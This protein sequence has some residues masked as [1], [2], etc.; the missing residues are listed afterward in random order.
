MYDSKPVRWE[1]HL[2]A[3][4]NFLGFQATSG[5]GK[6]NDRG[7]VRLVP[8]KTR[9]AAI[10]PL[11]LA[12]K[13]TYTWGRQL[14]DKSTKHDRSQDERAAYLALLDRCVQR[15]SN[16]E[17][18]TILGFLRNWSEEAQPLPVEMTANDLCTFVVEGI[19]PLDDPDVQRF[20]ARE[21]G[22]PDASGTPGQCLVCGAQTLVVDRLPVQLKGL[23]G[24]QASGVALVSANSSAFE[25]YGRTAA[26]TSPICLD[27]GER[28]GKAA[29]ALIQG[30]T[31]HLS[32]GPVVYL[33]WTPQ[34]EWDVVGF[35]KE[36]D[37]E[38]VRLLLQSAWT[39]RLRSPSD[40]EAFYITALS[41]AMSR[42][43][44]RS[45]LQTTV[46]EVRSSLRRWFALQSLIGPDGVDG[47][48]LSVFRL[49]VSLY[50]EAK[51]ILKRVPEALIQN[52]LHGGPLPT[53]LIHQAVL[54]NQAERKVTYPRAALIKAVLCSQSLED[55]TTMAALNPD[56]P[57]AAYHCGRL[58]AR[59]ESIQQAAVPGIKATLVDRYYAG[60][61]AAPA[62]VFGTLLS[63]AQDHL[64]KL[65]KNERGTY[66]ALSMSLEQILAAVSAFPNTLTVQDQALFSL[67][68]YHQRA[69]D[70]AARQARSAAKRAAQLPLESAS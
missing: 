52:A 34:G 65:R 26:L 30:E 3:I 31:T 39:G 6:R 16:P 28:F 36:P 14:D 25:S 23:P 49:S 11:L 37:P 69:D 12:D 17:V 5:G 20:W 51:D 59:L 62:R 46:G 15:T 33:F 68:Y 29:T 67:G 27:C 41:A 7:K 13:A 50:R 18:T 35:L 53:W 1:V 61:S 38:Q 21:V 4:G 45:W 10:Q 44:V 43:V 32:V 8:F 63:A 54:R 60:A 56:H 19:N 22:D 58:L 66:E 40:D 47:E 57:S 2:D 48:P 55:P 70:R 42:A 64:G 24:G 9:T